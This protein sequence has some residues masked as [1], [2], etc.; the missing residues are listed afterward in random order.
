MRRQIVLTVGSG[1]PARFTARLMLLDVDS[2]SIGRSLPTASTRPA[3]PVPPPGFGIGEP[4]RR[5]GR[6][7]GPAAPSGAGGRADQGRLRKPA[8]SSR[9]SPR[10][11]VGFEA[12]RAA[13][14]RPQ[15]RLWPALTSS[16]RSRGSSRSRSVVV[17][18][19]TL[20][21]RGEIGRHGGDLDSGLPPRTPCA[22]CPRTT[23]RV[24][25]LAAGW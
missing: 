8:S 10:T 12:H 21:C 3:S 22:S 13:S 19:K 20:R 16:T 7:S 25:E 18:E 9:A 24:L 5:A 23:C 2:A 14:A 17:L 4:A 11:A 1:R 6:P 15:R